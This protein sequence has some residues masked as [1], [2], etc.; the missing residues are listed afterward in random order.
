MSG[1][2]EN[3][4]RSLGPVLKNM[5]FTIMYFHFHSILHRNLSWI[6]SK[7][8]QVGKG[9]LFIFLFDAIQSKNLLLAN[10][11]CEIPTTNEEASGSW[12][13]FPCSIQV[14]ILTIPCYDALSNVFLQRACKRN[15]STHTVVYFIVCTVS[16]KQRGMACFV[17]PFIW[18]SLLQS[19][20]S[21]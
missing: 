15:K 3:Q 5:H 14:R 6:L 10:E 13:R 8:Y 12:K 4:Q 17:D 21:V 1:A 11:I 7:C 19:F 9:P 2:Y 16:V 20:T 18:P